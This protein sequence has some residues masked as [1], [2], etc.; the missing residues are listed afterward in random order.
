MAFILLPDLLQPTGFCFSWEDAFILISPFCWEQI[1][2]SPFLRDNFLILLH[3]QQ[4][5]TLGRAQ[6]QCSFQ[7][8]VL[9]RKRGVVMYSWSLTEVGGLGF[10]TSNPDESSASMEPERSLPYS[11]E[12]TTG[13]CSE[14]GESSPHRHSQFL[15]IHFIIVL[16]SML[17][18][19]K[20]SLSF[21]FYDLKCV[22]IGQNFSRAYCM[23][24]SSAPWLVH[25]IMNV[26]PKK[27]EPE[28]LRD[29]TSRSSGKDICIIF[30]RSRIQISTRRSAILAEVFRRFPRFLRANSVILGLP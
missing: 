6:S 3:I 25:V 10:E 18:S 30:G 28:K 29:G 1:F 22:C 8:R 11:P 20:W 15:K 9:L 12:S 17:K 4:Q 27:F 5:N 16:A 21:W 23:S 14:P 19:P 13:P 2:I 26:K 24:R 7:S